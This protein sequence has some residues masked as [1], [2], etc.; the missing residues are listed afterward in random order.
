M[1]RTI[2]FSWQSD[3]DNKGHRNFIERCIKQALKNLSKVDDAQIYMDYDRDTLGLDGS[4]DITSAI[5]DKIEK[6]VLYM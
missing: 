1:A 4:P 5:F 6:S 2:F 3:L